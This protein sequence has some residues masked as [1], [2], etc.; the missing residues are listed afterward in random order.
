MQRAGAGASVGTRGTDESSP[1]IMVFAPAPELTVTIEDRGGVPDL[2][3]HAGSQGVWQARI[4]A[5][6]GVRVSLVTALG[7]ETGNVLRTLLTDD[8]VDV[9]AHMV[10]ASSGGY[11]HDRR[12]GERTPLAQAP[13]EPLGRHDLDNLYETALVQGIEAGRALLSGPTDRSIIPA[14]LYR[15]LATDLTSNGCQVFVD[16]SGELLDAAL[17]GGVTFLKIS[18][19]EL[20]EDGRAAGEEPD[21]LMPAMQKLRGAGAEVVVVS[22]AAEPA[23]ALLPEGMYEVRTPVLQPIDSR[24]SGDS[25]TGAVAACIASGRSWAEAVRVGAAAGAL[26]VTRRG[27]ASANGHD[28]RAIVDRVELRRYKE[29]E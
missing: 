7:G 14:E 8:A 28:I 1:Q 15:R 22:R 19:Q 10:N 11:V 5:S 27:L 6:L 9:H 13:G 21:Q 24:G 4:I 29:P 18:H 3:L 26:N 2:H 12:R 25:M 20:L 16:L 17:E 23:L